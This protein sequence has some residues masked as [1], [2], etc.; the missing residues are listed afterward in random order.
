MSGVDP[1][2]LPT[3]EA[4][5]VHIVGGPGSGKTTLA[6]ALALLIGTTA[7]GLDEI[8]L[9][10]D[11]APGFRSKRALALREHDVRRL[12]EG[13]A[14]VTEGSYLWWA[15]P[16]FDRAQSI[17]WVDPP[18]SVAARRILTRHVRGYSADIRR[19]RGLRARLRAL[20]Y[21]HLA[22]LVGFFRWSARYYRSADEGL[23]P[24][25][26]DEM[27]ALTR[28]ATTRFLEA[29]REKVIRLAR[30][31][32][33]MAAHALAED[34]RPSGVRGLHVEAWVG[35]SAPR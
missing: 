11:T 8:A 6:G 35:G 1:G 24:V 15:R 5:R 34:G 29:Y 10:E 26:P 17:I 32:L 9:S 3:I 25:D 27:S 22:H 20:R 16:L 31:D 33:P 21:P 30:P 18:W 23:Q 13:G 14:W 19:A 4:R 28:A 2:T 12:S 7:H